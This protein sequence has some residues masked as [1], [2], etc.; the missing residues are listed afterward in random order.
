[1]KRLALFSC[2]LFIFLFFG[3]SL[4]ER[5]ERNLERTKISRDMT[6][7][8]IQ[9]V[10]MRSDAGFSK[11]SDLF[12]D[13]GLRTVIRRYMEHTGLDSFNASVAI[14]SSVLKTLL[15]NG[16]D[17][18]EALKSI[19]SNNH[20]E[21]TVKHGIL[22]KLQRSYSSMPLDPWGT[23]YRIFVGPWPG[24]W[25]PIVFRSYN[26]RLNNDPESLAASSLKLG[27]TSLPSSALAPTDLDFYIWSFGPNKI[28]DQALFPADA[29][30]Y[31]VTA[32]GGDDPHN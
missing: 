21:Q 17:S 32:N 13:V 9:L 6:D 24:D 18:W 25:G 14:Y 20:F 7:L 15:A 19:D 2:V 10:K 1:M 12:D 28:S 3:L 22:P 30:N 16:S 31:S 26:A 23:E 11:T 27:R 5:V 8:E 29:Y 4:L